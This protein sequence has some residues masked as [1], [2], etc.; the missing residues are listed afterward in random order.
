M[1]DWAKRELWAIVQIVVP[2]DVEDAV[3]HAMIVSGIRRMM[4]AQQDEYLALAKEMAVK[5]KS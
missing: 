5:E 3:T 4:E 1:N 2:N